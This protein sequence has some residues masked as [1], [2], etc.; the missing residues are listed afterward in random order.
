MLNS[1]DGGN[2]D[3]LVMIIYL[4]LL[5]V[6]GAYWVNISSVHTIWKNF[7]T[8]FEEKSH[9]LSYSTALA[10]RI[11]GQNSFT[12]FEDFIF[13]DVFQK[14]VFVICMNRWL[15]RLDASLMAQFISVCAHTHFPTLDS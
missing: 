9:F 11:K 6:Y 5:G 14:V 15:L 3:F 13:H 2:L 8:Q 4:F 1:T 10:L 7:M 12:D